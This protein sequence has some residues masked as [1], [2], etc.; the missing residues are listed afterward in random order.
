MLIGI[1]PLLS[2]DLLH[3]LASMGHG[4]E[5]VLA[6]ANFPAATLGKRLIRLPG[7]SAPA[8]LQAVLSVMPLDSFVEQPALTMQ[9][10]G[11]SLTRPATVAEFDALLQQQGHNASAA[12][13]RQAFYQRAAQAFA[14]VATGELRT[15]GNI[16]LKKGVIAA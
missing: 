2:P 16:L 15:Y 6:D 5:I 14:V 1:S 12:I 10:V 9:I 7:V 4:D 3:A 11:D 8:A 13:E